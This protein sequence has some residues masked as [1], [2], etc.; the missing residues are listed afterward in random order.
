V[1]ALDADPVTLK[2]NGQ[3]IFTFRAYVGSISPAERVTAISARLDRLIRTPLLDLNQIEVREE[4]GL[5]WQI[6]NDQDLLLVITPEDAKGENK[7]GKIVAESVAFR[8]KD[9]IAADRYAKTPR[10][11]LIKSLYALLYT[12][13]LFILLWAMA[14]THRTLIKRISLWEGTIIRSIQIKNFQIL[15]VTRITQIAL[16]LI[17]AVRLVATILIFYFYF[18]M[19]LGLFPWTASISEMLLGYII[20]PFRAILKAFVDFVPNLFFIIVSVLVARY[21]LKFIRTFF[22]AIATKNL[23]FKGFYPEWAEPTFQLVRILV[24]AFSA[25]VI[26]PYIPGSSSPAFQGVSVFLGVLLS[27]GSTSA[28]A[29]VISGLVLTYMRSFGLGDRVRIADAM[30]DVV[31]KSLL[32][33]RIRTVKNVEIT[34]PNSLVLNSHMINFSAL[35]SAEGLI[36]HLEV[37]IGYDAPWRTVHELLIQAALSTEGILEKPAPFVY[38]TGLDDSY[39]RYEV[40][41]YTR[42]ANAM[43]RV[44]SAMR[45]KIQDAFNTAGVEIMSPIYTAIR[46]GNSVTIPPEK[47]E[48]GY[49]A[50]SFR[51]DINDQHSGFHTKGRN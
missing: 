24:I 51:F 4:V 46:D 40:N 37:T 15:P 9:I 48:P 25:V 22:Q 5:G 50:P 49:K 20:A 23:E 17:K 8:L 43:A 19:V 11:L 34:I 2:L 29:N 26:F 30:G 32:V 45:E 16:F 10:E 35:A 31:E 1:A 28:M 44:Y 41:A 47:R 38:Q 42:E 39:V 33:T 3:T 21:V 6:F 27:F 12:L 14:R 13:A 18:P 36:L 7:P